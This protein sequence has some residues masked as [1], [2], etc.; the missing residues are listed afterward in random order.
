LGSA[1]FV[2]VVTVVAVG[3]AVKDMYDCN[4][5]DLVTFWNVEALSLAPKVRKIL[6][7]CVIQVTVE[8]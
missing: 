8:M 3:E 7:L 5:F 4:H 2:L 1:C 6:Y